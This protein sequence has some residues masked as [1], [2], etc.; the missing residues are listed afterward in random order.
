MIEC[1]SMKPPVDKRSILHLGFE[2]AILLKAINAVLEM[3]AGVLLWFVKPETMDRWVQ[4]LTENELAE[5]PED[6]IANLLLRAGERY[7]AEAH[8]FGVAYLVVHG[9]MKAVIVLLLW[10]KKLW[11]YPVSAGVLVVFISF[12]VF[13]WTTTHAVFLLALSVF[14]AILVWLIVVEYRRL[15]GGRS[16]TPAARARGGT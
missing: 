7:T 5:D 15:K 12:Q 3:L 6:L 1:A 13:R 8:Q 16:T 11:A 2:I 10:R 9:L 14:D 4:I